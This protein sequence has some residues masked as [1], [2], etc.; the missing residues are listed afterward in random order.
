MPMKHLVAILRHRAVINSTTAICT[1]TESVSRWLERLRVVSVP[2]LCT[3]ER[4][5]S[6][7]SAGQGGPNPPL[8]GPWHFTA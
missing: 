7:R 5:N 8:P 2:E 3:R 1:R 6:P 4:Y